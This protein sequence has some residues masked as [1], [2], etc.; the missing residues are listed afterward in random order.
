MADNRRDDDPLSEEIIQDPIR[1][2]EEVAQ[3]QPGSKGDGSTYRAGAGNPSG[4]EADDETIV[5]SRDQ[6]PNKNQTD[7]QAAMEPD[8]DPEGKRNTM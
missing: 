5:R 2:A 6:K 3:N 1:P 8:S 4:D 7:T